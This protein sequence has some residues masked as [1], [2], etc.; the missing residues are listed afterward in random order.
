MKN[1]QNYILH[2]PDSKN[3]AH[4]SYDLIRDIEI[5]NKAIHHF[6]DIKK[7]SSGS[8]IILAETRKIIGTHIGFNKAEKLI[9]EAC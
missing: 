3:E 6:C 9:V 5:D 1:A 8:P 7:G 4:F 2:Y